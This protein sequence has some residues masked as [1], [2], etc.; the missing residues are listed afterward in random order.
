METGPELVVH[1]YRLGDEAAYVP[2]G[3]FKS[4]DVIAAPGLNWARVEVAELTEE[5]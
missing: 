3:V 1:T 5:G 4:G 2:T